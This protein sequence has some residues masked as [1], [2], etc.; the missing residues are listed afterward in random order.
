MNCTKC[1]SSQVHVTDTRGKGARCIYR[2]RHCL[3]CGNRWTTLELPVGDLR[4]AV[5]VIN[6]LEGRK[7]GKKHPAK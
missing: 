7:H 1:G 5:G 3:A 4:Q 2:R 6:G